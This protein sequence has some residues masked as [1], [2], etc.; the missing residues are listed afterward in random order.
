MAEQFRVI[1]RD[2]DGGTIEKALQFLDLRHPFAEKMRGVLTG[3]LQGMVALVNL[4]APGAA[5]DA[6]IFHAGEPAIFRRGH[7][8][9]DVIKIQVEPDVPVEIAVTRV[10][11]VTFVFAPHLARGIKIAAESGNA[12]GRENRRERA[13]PR[14]RRGM[15]QT[16]RIEN[17]PAD[18]RLL[19]KLFHAFGVSAFGQPDAAGVAPETRRVVVA[20][21]RIWARTEGR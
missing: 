12:I 3:G 6:V 14:P 18:V 8:R 13:E 10:A 11:G 5:G 15:E 1:G 9:L 21:G 16:V 20:R 7:M 17:E 19:Q 2:D 4:L